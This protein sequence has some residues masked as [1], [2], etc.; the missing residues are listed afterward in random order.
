M[1]LESIKPKKTIIMQYHTQYYRVLHG[2]IAQS[3][4]YV[5]SEISKN[6]LKGLPVLISFQI[7]F[8]YFLLLLLLLFWK[9]VLCVTAAQAVLSYSLTS[10]C[11]TKAALDR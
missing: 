9:T 3:A 4:L 1:I 11:V 6:I 2:Y 8:F 7:L 10:C 5:F